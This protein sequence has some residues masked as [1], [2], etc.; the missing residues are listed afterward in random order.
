MSK[1]SISLFRIDERAKNINE[2]IDEVVDKAKSAGYGIVDGI[3]N[4]STSTKEGL[5]VLGEYLGLDYDR[6]V[7]GTNKTQRDLNEEDIQ[8]DIDSSNKLREEAPNKEIFDTTS[9]RTD[10]SLNVVST[11]LV[12]HDVV[13]LG[14]L[15]MNI[16]NIERA[17]GKTVTF[18]SM[19]PMENTFKEVGN[20]IEPSKL[21]DVW[22]LG[23]T[24]RGDVIEEVLAST[25]YKDWYNIGSS[26]GGYFPVIDFQKGSEVVSFKTIDPT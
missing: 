22:K 26:Q 7:S 4:F 15:G 23:A 20:A 3:G 17:T 12:V 10:T 16:I 1:L 14:K 5:N 9:S 13:Q 19:E 2:L 18:S 11:A 8:R 21:S 25:E 24:E 6:P